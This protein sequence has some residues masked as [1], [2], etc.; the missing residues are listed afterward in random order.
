MSHQPPNSRLTCIVIT[1]E[2]QS[3][4]RAHEHELFVYAHHMQHTS[5]DLQPTLTQSHRI[6]FPLFSEFCVLCV[7]NQLLVTAVGF[8]PCS[9]PVQCNQ[10]MLYLFPAN[11]TTPLSLPVSR[12]AAHSRYKVWLTTNEWLTFK[13]HGYT[14][15]LCLSWHC[16]WCRFSDTKLLTYSS[17]SRFPQHH[18]L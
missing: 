2:H 17:G 13:V 5:N 11:I 10:W 18:R 12:A 15:Q 14:P 8:Y 3:V 6:Q 9:G 1:K 4:N 16:T 7:H